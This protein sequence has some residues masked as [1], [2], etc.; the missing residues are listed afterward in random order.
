MALRAGTPLFAAQL[1][2]AVRSALATLGQAVE[3]IMTFVHAQTHA[4]VEAALG[5]S[6]FKAAVEEGSRWSMAEAVERVLTE[7][8]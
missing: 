7:E 5:E 2:G 4:K 6:A 8:T 3:P 1:L